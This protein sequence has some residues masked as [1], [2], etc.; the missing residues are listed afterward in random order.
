[1]HFSPY[2]QA[3]SGK[4]WSDCIFG[5]W[6]EIWENGSAMIAKE[7]WLLSQ[8]GYKMLSI[9]VLTKSSSFS[10]KL[11]SRDQPA[12]IVAVER[13]V[14]HNTGV[15]I[16]ALWDQS[17]KQFLYTVLDVDRKKYDQLF[18]L[19]VSL[20]GFVLSLKVFGH[21][22]IIACRTPV[23][24]RT[25]FVDA[26]KLHIAKLHL[27]VF[28]LWTSLWRQCPGVPIGR[29]QNLDIRQFITESRR[30]RSRSAHCRLSGW[31]SVYCSLFSGWVK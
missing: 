25:T 12:T 29:R 8:L 1:M 28:A 2:T 19:K 7:D 31:P 22:P 5:A 11:R 26:T 9:V 13:E 6:T 17:K 10:T 21:I 27:G 20:I 23:K 24:D 4:A 30:E 15:H 18:S 3:R 16:E 14:N